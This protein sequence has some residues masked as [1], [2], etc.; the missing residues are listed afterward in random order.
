MYSQHLF[1]KSEAPEETRGEDEQLLQEA[2]KE[3]E[4]LLIAL[5]SSDKD[6]KSQKEKVGSI[7]YKV[8]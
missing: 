7:N 1:E 3:L 2:Q 5:T 6:T 8:I 4:H